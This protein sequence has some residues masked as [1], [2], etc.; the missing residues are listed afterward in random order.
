MAVGLPLPTLAWYGSQIGLLGN[1]TGGGRYSIYNETFNQTGIP[2]AMSILEI[3]A[4]E[5]SD[6][7]QYSCVAYSDSGYDSVYF[8]LTVEEPLGV[9]Q[10]ECRCWLLCV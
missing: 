7:G 10:C 4:A 6:E 3:C 2:F 8:N 9:W 1:T 5:F